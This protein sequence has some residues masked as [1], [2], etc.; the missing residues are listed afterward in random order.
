MPRHIFRKITRNLIR[1]TVLA[2]AGFMNKIVKEGHYLQRQFHSVIF[3]IVSF[4]VF[5]ILKN[6]IYIFNSPETPCVEQLQ[7]N[8]R[9][10][11][12]WLKFLF[13]SI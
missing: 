11:R 9:K 4:T 2:L 8:C 5:H 12:I 6:S 7:G 13:I 1:N 3:V 10:K